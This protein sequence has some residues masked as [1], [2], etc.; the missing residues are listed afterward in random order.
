MYVRC[1]VLYTI[2]IM[3]RLPILF[4]LLLCLL[5]SCIYIAP[6]T[7]HA[8][9]NPTTAD[10]RTDVE[11]NDDT[12]QTNTA[13]KIVIN[14]IHYDPHVKTQAGEYIELYNNGDSAVD[15]SG[16][17]LAGA[18]AFTIPYAVLE[19]GQYLI[20]AQDP[21]TALQLWNVRAIGPYSGK[22]SAEGETITI[23]D[24]NATIVDEVAYQLGFPWPTV[25]DW[26]GNSIGLIHPELDNALGGSWRSNAPTPAARNVQFALD[27]P[28]HLE[29]VTHLPR[30]PRPNSTVA[31][32]AR[33]HDPNGVQRVELSY[34]IVEPGQ[35]ISIAD[36]EYH[37]G[38]TTIAM[39]ST[40]DVDNRGTLYRV[41]LPPDVQQ[42]R[43]LIRYRVH[44]SDNAGN[45]VT[46]P[47]ADDGQPNFAYFVYGSIP[48]WSGSVKPGV[49]PPVAYDFN[50]MSPLPIYHLISRNDNV[51]AALFESQYVGG[52]YPW[53]GTL[54]YGD[55]VY[56]HIGYRARGGGWRYALGKNMAKFDFNR[57][58][59]FQGYDDFGK[60]HPYKWDK[61]NL[62]AIIQ[63]PHVRTRGEHG[64]SE[65]IG[66]KLFNLAGVAAPHT[67]Y[68]HFRII[69]DAAEVTADQYEGDF[70][71]LYLAVEQMDGTFLKTHELPDGNLY[72]MEKPTGYLNNQGENAVRDR[73]DLDAFQDGYRYLVHGPRKEWWQ[74][75]LDLEHYYSFRAIVEGIHHYDI[76]EGKN[77]FFYLNPESERWQIHPWDIDQ[78]WSDTATGN[79]KEPF[80]DAKIFNH[81]GLMRD[82]RN[83]LREIRDLLYNR[84]Q[85]SILINRYAHLIDTP[86]GV[87]SMVEADR[88]M[89][90]HNP[91][92]TSSFINRLKVFPGSYYRW[93]PSGDFRGMV[94]VLE[95]Y[96][97]QRTRWIDAELLDDEGVPFQP[98][99][100]YSGPSNYPADALQFASSAFGSSDGRNNFAAMKWRL[101]ELNYPGLPTYDPSQPDRYEIEASWES[102]VLSSFQST[103]DL[104][105]GSCRPGRTC[106]ARVRMKGSRGR[107]SHWSEPV[108]FVAGQPQRQITNVLKI[109]EIMYN[110]GNL[111]AT[112]GDE[113]EFLEIKNVDTQRLDLSGMYFNTAI[114]Y[115][116]PQGSSIEGLEAIV[117]ASNAEFFQKRYGFAPFG[118]YKGQLKNG[119]ERIV[120]LDPSD[121]F[122][123]AVE[124]NNNS[125]WP[126]LPEAG[127]YSLVL[128][129]Y[130]TWLTNLNDPEQWRKSTLA[131]GSPLADDPAEIIINEILANPGIA[132][133]Q[134][135]ELWN[136]TRRPVKLDHWY[137]SDNPAEPQKYRFPADTKV[138][139]G[140]FRVLR[141][142]EF[143]GANN[144]NNDGQGFTLNPLGGQVSLFSATKSG[145]FTGYQQRFV[146]G[147]SEPGYS[148]GR[149][150]T[151][152]GEVRYPLL[153]PATMGASNVEPV[154]GPVVVTR[155]RYHG[156]ITN[157]FIELTNVSA[158]PVNLYDSGNTE[159]TWQLRGI[160]FDFPAGVTLQPN[161]SLFLVPTN[162]VNF[163]NADIIQAYRQAGN[164]APRVL[165]PY[166]SSL[167]ENKGEFVLLRPGTK[168][169]T[170]PRPYYPVDSVRYKKDLPWPTI[171]GNPGALLERVTPSAY[172][173][174][175]LSWVGSQGQ[176]VATAQTTPSAPNDAQKPSLGPM[177]VLCSIDIVPDKNLQQWLIDANMGK[178]IIEWAMYSEEGMAGYNLLGNTTDS[179]ATAQ[180]INLRV[181]PVTQAN[182]ANANA[183]AAAD[184]NPL[185][186][187]TYEYYTTEAQSSEG[188]EG[189]L[190]YDYYWLEAIGTDGSSS[191]VAFTSKREP[192][193]V[194]YLPLLDR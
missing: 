191:V 115:E 46:T 27:A 76:S 183:N 50:A 138:P 121:R 135:I 189:K 151:S 68:V 35:Y 41:E 40:S 34:Q 152:I 80:M 78:T 127:G 58:H 64:L 24:L 173:D 185:A 113:L 159:D 95:A 134:S 116:F 137:L 100:S 48:Q 131:V 168:P 192:A 150:V 143:S 29:M 132:Q 92:M 1:R 11:P 111:G 177:G 67:N 142:S 8:A 94:Q 21:D 154:N 118:E 77:F 2:Y 66:Y 166:V 119:G 178:S 162:P 44:A 194:I 47:Y 145:R 26:P 110:P 85:V 88:M 56:D 187:Y 19:P 12:A 91:I 171:I 65:T 163:C 20:I 89:W 114:Q 72:K 62:S 33:V 17:Q 133:V 4:L 90:D 188:A 153:N 82:Y 147:S 15:L 63:H 186:T 175:P 14:E 83:R 75:N 123:F 30:Q 42:H 74:A 101:T 165:G 60:P 97:K 190:G 51:R 81:P 181:I 169:Q 5:A 124:Y 93:S 3:N 25:G 96:V 180:Q 155:L 148:F 117:L 170:G 45:E 126:L 16:W 120:L 31:I 13:H 79:G 129:S 106:R 59:Y 184:A 71:G 70:M 52:D 6:H 28:P 23:Y 102:E 193:R 73:S 57:G 103:I 136:P 107:W 54:V 144:G 125:P 61:L 179:F 104:P 32:S 39:Q 53:K 146:Y 87:P 140:G 158:A 122:V 49:D 18:V 99:I 161:E 10:A 160:F 174:D 98:T 9:T 149:H 172:G 167:G 86:A 69:D 7:L 156:D 176:T 43:R 112:P 55:K 130:A 108:E 109:S 128:D 164:R 141:V 38:W 157:E 84:E 105:H 37:S 36:A 182:G 22:L 139:A